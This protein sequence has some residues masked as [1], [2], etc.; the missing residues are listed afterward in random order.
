VVADALFR[1]RDWIAT[2]PAVLVLA[3]LLS[4]SLKQLVKL[5]ADESVLAVSLF[6]EEAPAPEPLPPPPRAPAEPVRPVPSRSEPRVEPVDSRPLEPAAP[7]REVTPPPP[8]ESTP[9]FPT[10]TP[11]P[12]PVREPPPPATASPETAYVGRLRAYL[13]SIKRYPTSREARSQRPQGKVRLWVEIA[14]DGQLR[15]AGVEQSS[16]SMILDGAALSTARQGTY[17]AFPADIYGG[18]AAQR[19]TVTLDYQLDGG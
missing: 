18:R 19:F 6:E 3:A 17:P 16:G 14:R 5:A 2:I 15:E 13:D 7:P 10:P 4:V 1:S 8:R 11:T 12:A 9:P